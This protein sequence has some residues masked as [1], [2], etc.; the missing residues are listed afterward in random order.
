MPALLSA[1]FAFT[2]EIY[3]FEN[4]EAKSYEHKAYL[5]PLLAP[6]ESLTM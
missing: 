2:P 6:C 5:Q 4:R 3:F 1:H